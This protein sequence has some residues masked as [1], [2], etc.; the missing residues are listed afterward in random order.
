[1]FD[2]RFYP[3]LW[4]L[5][6][7]IPFVFIVK[8][9]LPQNAARENGPIENFQLV[10]LAV[11]IY[12]C[13]QAM[14]KTRVSMDKYIWQAGMLFYILVFGRELSWGRALLMQSDGIMPK[15][16]ELGIWGDIAHPLI[17]ILIA[18]LLFLFWRGRFLRFLKTV[19]IPMWDLIFLVL[20]IVLVDISEHYNCSIF[21][22]SSVLSSVKGIFPSL[23]FKVSLVNLY[24]GEAKL[25]VSSKLG[26]FIFNIPQTI[27]YIK[28]LVK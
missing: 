21:Y 14:K 18:L 26:D 25:C 3:H 12:L 19:K 5:I 1:M 2:K 10:L 24:F 23:V 11:G 20:F 28:S 8:E 15:W 4:L 27:S 13:W 9:F 16:R 7:Y 17:G 6:I 22:F